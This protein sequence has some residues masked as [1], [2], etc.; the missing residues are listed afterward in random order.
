MECT[1]LV[2]VSH[3]NE[4]HLKAK[5]RM[6]LVTSFQAF[7][8]TS[9]RLLSLYYGFGVFSVQYFVERTFIQLKKYVIITSI[10]NVVQRY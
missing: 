2:S 1:V 9:L 5:R 3:V 4:N 8:R 10:D 7:A 6:G